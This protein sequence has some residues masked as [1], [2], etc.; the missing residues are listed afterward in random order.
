M[1]YPRCFSVPHTYDKA[2]Y[3]E[4]AALPPDILVNAVTSS[5]VLKTM[6][7]RA[8]S[9]RVIRV[10]LGNSRKCEVCVVEPGD[11]V[12]KAEG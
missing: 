5:G 8:C 2:A 4:V 12:E 3:S 11:R 1:V 7:R 9:D 10:S 6:S